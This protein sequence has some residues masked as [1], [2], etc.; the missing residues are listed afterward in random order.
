MTDLVRN[1]D[2]TFPPGVSGNPKGRPPSKKNV[3]T[4][5][6]QDLEIAIRKNVKAEDVQ[7]IVDAMVK[8]AKEGSVNA[9]KLILDKTISNAKETEDEKNA[10]KGIHIVIENA[11]AGSRARIA[12]T[13]EGEYT[14]ETTQ[15]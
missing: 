7:D 6:K 15:E 11:T 3:L 1:P 5:L 8:V 9:A 13:V 14:E 2:G 10:N 4:N 12:E